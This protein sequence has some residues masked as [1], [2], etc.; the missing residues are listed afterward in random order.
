MY[1]EVSITSWIIVAL[2]CIW[3]ALRIRLVS[4]PA[5]GLTRY[6]FNL[7]GGAG[8]GLTISVLAYLLPLNTELRT[9][10]VVAGNTVLMAGIAQAW[11]LLWFLYLKPHKVPKFV[12]LVPSLVYVAGL[13]ITDYMIA[14]DNPPYIDGSRY[15]I[16]WNHAWHIFFALGFVSLV[17]LGIYFL[18]TA[19]SN[20]GISRLRSL[21]W[22]LLFLLLG[23][24]TVLGPVIDVENRDYSLFFGAALFIFLTLIYFIGRR[25]QKSK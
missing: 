23:A 22:G 3:A 7:T 10:L 24:S 4:W 6:V 1:S 9:L 17:I 2:V 5:V 20:K 8:A 21:T 18:K 13:T 25:L 19:I 12:V 14:V 16:Y 15:L 11:L